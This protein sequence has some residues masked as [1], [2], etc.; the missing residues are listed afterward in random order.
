MHIS[1][2]E[3]QLDEFLNFLYGKIDSLLIKTFMLGLEEEDIKNYIK[4]NRK[5]EKNEGYFTSSKR[6]TCGQRRIIS[7]I[8]I[9]VFIF[10]L[11]LVSGY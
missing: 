10:Y 7:N 6:N 1:I 11:F 8:F 9:F 3:I 5:S 2:K 4:W